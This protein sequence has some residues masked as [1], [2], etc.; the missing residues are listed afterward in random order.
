MSSLNE[1][2]LQLPP[3]PLN[4]RFFLWRTSDFPRSTFG[5]PVCAPLFFPLPQI[6][7][8]SFVQSPLVCPPQPGFTF[9]QARFIR[10]RF[11]TRHSFWSLTRPTRIPECATAPFFLRFTFSS[12]K[13]GLGPAFF[14]LFEVTSFRIARV[15]ALWVENP[16]ADPRPPA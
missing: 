6:E 14:F 1:V 7:A 2:P 15:S 12:P 9:R 16:S 13:Q 3:E 10:F 4:D 5:L 11:L 8:T